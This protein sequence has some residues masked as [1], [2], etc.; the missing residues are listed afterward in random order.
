MINKE[1]IKILRNFLLV[2][3]LGI[4]IRLKLIINNLI[5]LIKSINQPMEKKL[6]K[7]GI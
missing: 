6:W 1:D 2:N 4:N 7:E 3:E 5:H